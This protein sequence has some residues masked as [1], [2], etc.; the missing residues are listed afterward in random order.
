MT[1]LTGISG[2]KML[3]KIVG[4]KG[5][6][7]PW[8]GRVEK[9]DVKEL[10]NAL[11]LEQAKTKLLVD[12][13]IGLEDEI[14]N[15]MLGDFEPVVNSDTREYWRGQLLENR[16]EA[17]KVLESMARLTGGEPVGSGQ[18]AVGSGQMAV[19]SARQPL[20]N[21]AQA[22]PA[23][24]TV[25]GEVDQGAADVKRAGLVRNRAQEIARAERIPFSVAFRRAER[26]VG[27]Q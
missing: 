22:R 9:M 7:R 13:V 10:E 3:K 16:A 26:E 24:R 21:R 25:A 11:Q 18:V 14:V 27:G 15:R 1:G 4:V 5:G 17:S 12:E 8:A 23:P 6:N 20:H 19:G 2:R